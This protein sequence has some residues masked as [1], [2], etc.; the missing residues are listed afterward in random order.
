VKFVLLSLGLSLGLAGA[1]APASAQAGR[2]RV[3]LRK[4]A[5]VRGAIIHLSDLLP[6]AAPAALRR[7]SAALALGRAP[8]PGTLRVLRAGQIA[9]RL[10]GKANLLGQISWPDQITVRR[11][12]WPIRQENVRDAVAHF[13]QE[14]EWDQNGGLDMQRLKWTS[15]FAALKPNPALEVAGAAWDSLRH[16]LRLRLRCA[17]QA[18]CGSF[19]VQWLVPQAQEA[20]WRRR[21]SEPSAF[22]T[23]RGAPQ[24]PPSKTLSGP[25]L[26]QPGDAAM[27]IL[28]SGGIRI[29]LP[30]VCLQRGVLRQ[31]I[32]ARDA[33]SH[34]IFQAQVIGTDLLRVTF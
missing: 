11:R 29:S 17:E 9:R 31:Q 6:A 16:V 32:R 22:A 15:D 5:E 13:L 25:P 14:R 1:C 12:G 30:V 28:E 23:N 20:L 26:T 24:A 10:A 34:R 18:L 4:N 2:D 21:L 3:P 27:L 8:Q 7:A 33:S 19:L